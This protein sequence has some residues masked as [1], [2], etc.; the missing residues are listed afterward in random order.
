MISAI[1]N[2]M[3]FKQVNGVFFV[4]CENIMLKE[5]EEVICDF[6]QGAGNSWREAK[7]NFWNSW[8]ADHPNV[9]LKPLT[10]GEKTPD[11][12]QF[13]IEFGPLK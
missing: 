6:H 4:T 9:F 3:R 12:V 10:N 13:H 7:Y 5:N 2:A 11:R 8:K 1:S